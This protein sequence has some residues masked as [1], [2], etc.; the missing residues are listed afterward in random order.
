MKW[1]Q[2]YTQII[3][4]AAIAFCCPGIFNALTGLGGAGNSTSDASSI[5]NAT[6]YA[7][8]AVFGYFGG[9]AFNRL[10]NR[11]LMA[12]G[13]VCYVIY[14]IG[15]YLCGRHAHL[16]WLAGVSGALLGI[17]AGW[18]W[19]AQGAMMMSYATPMEKG[20]F[21]STFWIIFNLG[22]TIGGLIAFAVNYHTEGGDANPASYFTFTALMALGAVGACFLLPPHKVQKSDGTMVEFQEVPSVMEEVKGALSVVN[23]RAMLILLIPFVSSNW[24]YTYQFN[25]YNLNIFTTRTRGFNSAIYWAAQMVGS[26]GLSLTLDRRS[27]TRRKR[28]LVSLLIT[29]CTINLAFALGCVVQYAYHGGFERAHPPDWIPIDFTESARAA[30]PIIVYILYGLGDAMW[31]TYAYWVMGSIAGSDTRLCARFAGFYKGVQSAG[32]A[33]AWGIDLKA[34]YKPQF[35]VC[36]VMVIISSP[37]LYFANRHIDDSMD[38]EDTL[39]PQDSARSL[40]D[41]EFATTG[42]PQATTQV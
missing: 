34:A 35:W 22:G 5:A 40:K 6:L 11:V 20:K 24:F 42:M 26:Y 32:A 23:H 30:F 10:G 41:L 4:V 7:C 15:M 21:I 1:N 3:L 25:G 12:V 33:I 8:F 27:W 29:V 17:G 31:Q 28:G 13:G 38:E 36:W 37:L 14:N 39:K 9:A 2:G 18:F 19:T 16:E